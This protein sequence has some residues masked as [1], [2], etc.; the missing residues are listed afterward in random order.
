MNVGYIVLRQSFDCLGDGHGPQ[1]GGIDQSLTAELVGAVL[2]RDLEGKAVIV[3]T[4]TEQTAVKRDRGSVGFCLALVGEHQGMRIDDAGQGRVDRG[5]AVQLG[6]EIA[7]RVAADPFQPACT[8]TQGI[9]KNT[10]EPLEVV[11]AVGH[12]ELPND[13]VGNAVFR[14]V[15]FERLLPC[16]AENRLWTVR[17]IVEAG[18]GDL[19]A[20]R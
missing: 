3:R 11:L 17:A 19:V 2:R 18:V 13:L 9:F 14:A 7:R 20:A 15:G 12:H 5:V 16:D 4:G 8:T 6:L 1:A 10:F